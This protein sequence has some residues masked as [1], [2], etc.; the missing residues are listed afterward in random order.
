M[1]TFG[2]HDFCSGITDKTGK[3][4]WKSLDVDTSVWKKDD[5][6]ILDINSKSGLYPLLAAYNVYSRKLTKINKH[7]EKVYQK[8]WSDVLKDNIYVLCK[9][10][11]AQS[12]TFRTLAGYNEMFK[13]NIIHVDNLVEKLQQKEN[14]KGY[15]FKVE[16]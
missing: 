4:E 15:N 12:I 10:P 13:T 7:E 16:L 1:N 9:S 5:T 8:I 2:G 6:K 3:P 14:Y 11:M